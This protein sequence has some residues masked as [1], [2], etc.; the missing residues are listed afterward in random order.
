LQGAAGIICTGIL[1]LSS[2]AVTAGG[3][4]VFDVV[5]LG[6]K[7]D[8]NTDDTRVPRGICIIPFCIRESSLLDH[9]LIS[10]GVYV[11]F[12]LKAFWAA[13]AAA[14]GA[15]APSATMLVPALRTFLVSPIEFLGPCA[16]QKITVQVCEQQFMR[17]KRKGTRTIERRSL[18]PTMMLLRWNMHDVIYLVV[19]VMGTVVA[20][21]ASTW[22][23]GRND[24]WLMFNRVNGLTVTG[25]GMLDGNGQSWWA[26][27]CNRVGDDLVSPLTTVLVIIRF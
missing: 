18:L 2:L 27:R 6:A 19:Q 13:W 24:H 20:P 17:T 15:K 11:F 1:V 8:G 14:C 22:R 12:H 23:G 7:G 3:E 5:A 4:P 16:S 25:R 9:F 21:P 26:R 10:A